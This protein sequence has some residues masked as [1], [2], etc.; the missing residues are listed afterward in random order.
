MVNGQIFKMNEKLKKAREKFFNSIATD[1]SN[2]R[3]QFVLLIHLVQDSVEFIQ[4]IEKIGDIVLLIAIPYSLDLKVL[5][6]LK[7][8]NV[9]Q[10][11]LTDLYQETFLFNIFEKFVCRT[12]PVI[13][14]EIGGYFSKIA[15]ELRKYYTVLG[16]VEDTEFGHRQYVNIQKNLS[17]PVFSVARSSLK[18]TEDALVGKSCIFSLEKILRNEG[19]I[20]NAQTALV[21]G[22]GKIGASLSRIL[23]Q[24]HVHVLVY[25][26]NPIKRLLALSEGY[27]V[28]DKKLGLSKADLILGATGNLSINAAEYNLLK[29]NAILISCSSKQAEFDLKALKTHFICKKISAYLDSYLVKEKNIYIMND[30]CPINFSE[31]KSLVGSVISLIQAEIIMG[32]MKILEKKLEHKIHYISENERKELAAQWLEHFC[33]K[34]SGVYEF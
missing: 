22:Y 14:I 5:D 15:L 13:L 21:I 2:Q 33:N 4:K 31:E 17:F 19:H 1:E 9:V 34:E 7:A 12:Q 24:H 26:E 25:D 20:L 3:V 32:V 18:A 28:P 10:A 6:N 8:Y 29:N 27:P 23:R 11:N 16:I 30:G